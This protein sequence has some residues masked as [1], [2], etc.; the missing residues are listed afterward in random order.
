MRLVDADL[1]PISLR[2]GLLA[3]RSDKCLQSMLYLWCD[4]KAVNIGAG[5]EDVIRPKTD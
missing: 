5:T 4:A 1:A 2:M 3:N